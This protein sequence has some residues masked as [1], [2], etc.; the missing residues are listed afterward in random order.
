LL[1]GAL[2]RNSNMK[3]VCK[4]VHLLP[5]TKNSLL[6]SK[7]DIETAIKIPIAH[8]EG[9][10]F[11]DAETLASLYA[12]DQI[13]FKY[14]DEDGEITSDANP[15]G[16]L[17]NIAGICNEKRNVFGMMPH[18]E[19]ASEKALFNADGKLIFESLVSKVLEMTVRF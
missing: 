1:P 18:P 7:L 16:S 12:N 13:L 4:N 9:R 17:D 11:C 19:R 3:Y 10:Y 8:G 14:S 15:N 2:L 6:T 5:Q